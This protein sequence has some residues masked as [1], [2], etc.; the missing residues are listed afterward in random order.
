MP[1]PLDDDG[2]LRRCR[3]CGEWKALDAFHRSPRRP[4]GRGSYCQ[5]CFNVRSRASYARQLAARG[6]QV[7]EREQLA[8]GLKRCPDCGEIKPVEEFA[9]TRARKRGYHTYC[10]PCH[11]QRGRETRERLYGGSRHYHLV[12]RYGIGAA[13]VDAMIAAQG[14]VCAICGA[15]APEHVDHD[16]ATGKVRGVLCFNCNGGLG[17][18]RDRVDV[19]QRAIAY[20]RGQTW[21]WVLVRPGVYRKRSPLRESRRSWSF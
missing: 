11:N 3:D 9:R 19:M 20:L 17:Q 5:P 13:D 16:H 2:G 8:A 10:L 15:A 1:R 4:S 21:Q 7:Q 6:R 14:G 18:F 12:R